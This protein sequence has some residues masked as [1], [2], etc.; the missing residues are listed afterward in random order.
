MDLLQV[1]LDNP[2][3]TPDFDPNNVDINYIADS[4]GVYVL[5]SMHTTSNRT[6]TALYNL[7]W[8]KEYA[9]ELYEEAQE[10]NKQC[11]GNE[12]TSRDFNKM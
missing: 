10:I 8:K 1:Y 2:R 12:L 11:N 7:A 3:V 9:Q 6:A 5:A 4:L